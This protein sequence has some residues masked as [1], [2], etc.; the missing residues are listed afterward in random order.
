MQAP[1][2][3]SQ[4]FGEHCASTVQIGR[5]KPSDAEPFGNASQATSSR[6]PHLDASLSPM[7]HAGK[8]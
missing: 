5:Q 7:V 6:S 8:Q 3:R 1:V 2:R 4:K